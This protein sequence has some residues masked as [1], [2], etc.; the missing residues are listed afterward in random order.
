MKMLSL[1]INSP[2]A[3]S[4]SGKKM[5]WCT[6]PPR[7]RG[8]N[9][10][11]MKHCTFSFR[12]L[13]VRRCQFKVQTVYLEKQE[14]LC[15]KLRCLWLVFNSSCSF[16]KNS[17]Y[18]RDAHN[19]CLS[20]RHCAPSS[21]ATYTGWGTI[22]PLKEQLALFIYTGIYCLFIPEMNYKKKCIAFD[23]LRAA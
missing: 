3:L 23:R 21:A 15:C 16:T 4:L 18:G 9:R 7:N 22:W 2:W 11:E 20:L 6:K 10:R 19:A 14:M 12:H 5:W 13:L 1:R 17:K 8:K